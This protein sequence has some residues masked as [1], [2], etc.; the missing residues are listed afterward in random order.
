L[1]PLPT[2][3]TPSGVVLPRTAP[4]NSTQS[5]T[6]VDSFPPT[7]FQPTPQQNV[8]PSV[9]PSSAPAASTDGSSPASSGGRAQNRTGKNPAA[10]TVESCISLWEAGTHMSKAEWNATCRRIQNRLANINFDAA[11]KNLEKR[12][13]SSGAS[14]RGKRE[15]ARMPD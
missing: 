10:E 7:R 3:Q 9:P 6:N 11:L 4:F 2:P 5:Q 13:K 8:A 15:A 12:Q 14:E 1:A